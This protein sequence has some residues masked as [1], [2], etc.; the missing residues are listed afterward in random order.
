MGPEEQSA[1]RIDLKLE[2]SILHGLVCEWEAA[3]LYLPAA[4]RDRLKPP[5]MRLGQMHRRWGYWSCSKREICLSRRLVFDHPWDAVCDV[6]RHEM[7]HQL[8]DELLAARHEKPHG[9][10]FLQACHLLRADPQ[11]SG[12]YPLLHQQLDAEGILDGHPIIRRVRKLMAL[13]QSRNRHEAEAAMIKAHD[14]LAKYNLDLVP[15]EAPRR[16][17]SVFVG[18]PA[19]RHFREAY[20]LAHLLTDFYYVEGIW[21]PAYVVAR[22]KVGRVLEISGTPSN[23]KIAAYVHDFLVR[24]IDSRWQDRNHVRG[25][26]RHR[27]TDFAMGIAQGFRSRL[28]SFQLQAHGIRPT[29]A[30]IT[31]EDP[32]LKSYLTHRYPRLRRFNRTSRHTDEDLVREGSRLGRWLVISQG[33][34]HTADGPQRLLENK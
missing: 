31:I 11:A 9:P 13:A 30:L 32:Q 27:K 3:R 28:E 33:I 19:L 25:L 7:A 5:L 20:A 8:A 17:V 14:L 21:V 18:S 24:F 1:D 22:G 4:Y 34:T 15:S 16:F 6:L 26:G 10:R 12:H 29:G 2:R 23:V